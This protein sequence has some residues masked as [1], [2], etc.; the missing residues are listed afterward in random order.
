[1]LLWTKNCLNC[2]K[3]SPY[4]VKGVFSTPICARKKTNGTLVIDQG[5]STGSYNHHH[6]EQWTHPPPPIPPFLLTQNISSKQI[7]PT[8]NMQPKSDGAQKASS[9]VKGLSRL[10]TMP[11]IVSLQLHSIHPPTPPGLLT[12][13]THAI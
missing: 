9:V 7:A 4:K 1:M 8:D 13:A 12:W 3:W 11:L 6:A 10:L 2:Q 5:Y